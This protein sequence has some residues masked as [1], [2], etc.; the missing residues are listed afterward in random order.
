MVV[1]KGLAF[2][3]PGFAAKGVLT[4]AAGTAMPHSVPPD[5]P[6]NRAPDGEIQGRADVLRMLDRIC[7]YYAANE[8]SSP[9]PLLLGRARGL[10]NKTFIDIL[11]DL[12]P[13]GVSQASGI[14]NPRSDAGSPDEPG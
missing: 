14:F 9:V 2:T 11:R 7:A 8:P 1:L 4:S 13:N 3:A 6:A 12:A 5:A 10:V